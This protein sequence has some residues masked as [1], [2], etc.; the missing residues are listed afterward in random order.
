MLC[1]I[2]FLEMVLCVDRRQ[3]RHLGRT[4]LLLGLLERR[5]LVLDINIAGGR[6]WRGGEGRGEEGLRVDNCGYRL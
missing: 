4:L 3:L 2:S 5:A 6:Q 1:K